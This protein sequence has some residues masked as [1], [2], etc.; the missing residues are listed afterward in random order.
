MQYHGFP[1]IGQYESECS[2]LGFSTRRVPFHDAAGCAYFALV[3]TPPGHPTGTSVE[4]WNL[5][6]ADETQEVLDGVINAHPLNYLGKLAAHG[7]FPDEAPEA[8]PPAPAPEPE[9]A[10]LDISADGQLRFLF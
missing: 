9:P 2:R 1:S 8:A 3:T 5:F 6:T 7:Y 4:A 10:A